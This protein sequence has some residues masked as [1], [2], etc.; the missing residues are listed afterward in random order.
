[1]TDQLFSRCDKN[2][3]ITC[4]D[5]PVR[6]SSVYNPGAVEVGDDVVLLLRVEDRK[7]FSNIHVARSADGVS[8]WH[9][10][11]E[12]LLAYGLPNMRYETLGC[13]D[14]RVTWIDEDGWYYITYVAYSSMGPAAGL[15]RTQDFKTGER[16]GL[17]F[18][19]NTQDVVM[20]PEKIGG[21]SHVL[22][23][24]ALGDI[25]HIWSAC[26]PDLIHWGM[27]HVVIPER[28]GPWW[29]GLKVGAAAPPLR[30]DRGW[31][32]VYHGVKA[33][34]G[35]LSYRVGLALLDLDEPHK[36]LKRTSEWVFG[37]QAHYEQEGIVPNIVFPSGTIRRDNEVWMYYGAADSSVCL[38]RA[39]LGDLMQVLENEPPE[40]RDEKDFSSC[41]SFPTFTCSDDT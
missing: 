31:L 23:R 40:P 26:S 38:A 27:P 9:I 41:R 22:H 13:E 20:F 30:T 32:L 29:D 19:P 21:L 2:P 17:V 4:D 5:L 25:E 3:I 18:A 11:A 12:P 35:V 24:P 37:P 34:A 6:A 7:G 15:A 8:N 39:R 10:D 36:V 16:V 14:A 1:M 33:L 28:G